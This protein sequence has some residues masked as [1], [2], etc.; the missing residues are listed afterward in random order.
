MDSINTL[1]KKYISEKI[2]SYSTNIFYQMFKGI[3]AAFTQLEHKVEILKRERNILSAQHL[4]SLRNLSAQ[5]GF[6]P[7]LKLPSTGIL[8]ITI[9]AKFFNTNGY[10]I[11]IK[12]YSIFTCEETKLEYVY[13]SNKT[14]KINSN[15][16]YIP[17][18]EGEINTKKVTGTG[19]TIDRFYLSDENIANNS[20]IVTVNDIT[21]KEVPSFFDNENDNDNKQYMVKFS[22]DISTPII[23]YIKGLALDDVAN[24]TYQ[25]T[26]GELGNITDTS[27]TF[28]C[29]DV[30]NSNGTELEL[31]IDEVVITNFSGF[32]LGSNGTDE[33]ALRAAIG[34]NHGNHLLY[35]CTSY[36]NFLAKFSTILI[37]KVTNGD[38][39]AI[40]NLYLFRKQSLDTVLND[41]DNIIAQYQS[42][43]NN[44]TYLLPATVK[45]N[46][47]SIL[48]EY[49]FALA[50]HNLYNGNVNKY[51]LQITFDSDSDKEIYSDDLKELIYIEFGKFLYN[52]NYILDIDILFSAFMSK[53]DIY[54]D[55]K[56]FD[57]NTEKLKLANSLSE[58]KT[59]TTIKHTDYLPI[60]N[61]NFNIADSDGNSYALFFDINIVSC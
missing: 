47:V 9:A 48:E 20:I 33:N 54:F 41:T 53:N 6:Q 32:D 1:L 4:I 46:I 13:T 36:K 18:S 60:L 45:A 23:V 26:S 55:Y 22:N 43:I 19:V 28:D 31:D 2:P 58:T 14:L 30:I 3:D 61:G 29:E 12:P 51:A 24:I 11:Y 15:V 8:K 56:L 42:I 44:K 17:V 52:R 21:Y 10:P 5:N 39:K 35:D 38:T 34:Y 40:N 16:A 37:Q 49:E 59:S 27:Y 7:T 57:E 50:S 25:L